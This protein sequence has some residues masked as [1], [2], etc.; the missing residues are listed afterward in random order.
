MGMKIYTATDERS[1]TKPALNVAPKLSTIAGFRIHPAADAFPLIEGPEYAQLV[2]DI[3]RNG[4]HEP[5]WA[6]YQAPTLDECDDYQRVP[7]DHWQDH[8]CNDH[9]RV[10][11]DDCHQWL[12]EEDVDSILDGRNRLRA[13]E[14][15]GIKPRFR[16]YEGDDPV[17]FVVSMNIHRRHL[18]ESQRGMIAAR[19]AKLPKGSNQHVSIDTSSRSQA[20]TLLNVGEATVSRGRAVLDRGVPELAAA[21]DRGDVA[22]SHAASIAKQ[23]PADQRETL[24]KI[25]PALGG[26]GGISSSDGYDSDEWYTPSDYLEAAR[27]V[28]GGFDLDPASCEHAQQRVKAARFYTKDDDGLTKKWIGRVWLNPPY[29]QPAAT[30]FAEKLIAEFQAGNVTSAIVVQNASTD[31][32]WFHALAKLGAICLTRGRINFDREDGRSSQNRYGQAFFYFG[33][34]EQRF[35][36]VFSKFGLVGRLRG[37]E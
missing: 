5:I 29:S 27:E 15:A 10:A 33:K 11:C 28:L 1:G 4:L 30:R 3:R 17:G 8:P 23:S 14:S 18:D 31:T 12:E 13:C 2:D 34:D 26:T 9:D 7:E 24:R 25:D 21:V 36:D 20:A 32:G 6:T 19:L 22:I 35:E 37:A 16:R